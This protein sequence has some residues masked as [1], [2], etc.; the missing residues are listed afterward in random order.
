MSWSTYYA[1]GSMLHFT[2]IPLLPGYTLQG[3]Y[4]QLHFT[5]EEAEAQRR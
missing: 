4:Y 1:P 5:G 3:H 2:Y